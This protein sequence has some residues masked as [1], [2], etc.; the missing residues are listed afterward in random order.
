MPRQK[1]PDLPPRSG[2]ESGPAIS[3]AS[4]VSWLRGGKVDPEI[5]PQAAFDRLFG[6]SGKSR[7]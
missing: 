7:R 5:N 4:T 1:A 2:G 6:E 3:F